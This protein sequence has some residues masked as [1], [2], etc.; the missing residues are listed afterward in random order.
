[1]PDGSDVADCTEC[2]QGLFCDGTNGALGN[3]STSCETATAAKRDQFTNWKYSSNG[4]TSISQCYAKCDDR[5]V[6]YGHAYPNNEEVFYGE[7]G[8]VCTF[9][10]VSES[11]NPCDIEKLADTSVYTNGICVE[12]AC[13]SNYEMIDGV[14]Q[15]CKRPDVR[16]NAL[17]FESFG[18][19]V[20]AQCKDGFHPRGDDCFE[21]VIDCKASIP[22]AS[23]ATSNWN[24]TTKT[25]G[26]CTVTDCVTGYHVESNACVPDSQVC[27]MPNGVG[28]RVWNNGKWGECEATSCD[29]GYMMDVNNQCVHCDN[30]FEENGDQAVSSYVR[31]CEIASCMYQGEKYAL[32]EVNGKMTCDPIC[33]PESDDTGYRRWNYTTNKCEYTCEPGYTQ[34]D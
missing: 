14:C 28:S 19:C 34:P 13:T 21:D 26:I 7:N 27:P 3:G 11:G 22:N 33:L 4:A 15:P 23:E 17:T 18:N 12:S 30:K 6:Q 24:A 1:M 2:A 8:Q 10:G 31:G 20:V 5:D 29:A 16:T 25:F 32:R 9:Y